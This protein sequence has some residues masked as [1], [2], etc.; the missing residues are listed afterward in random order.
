MGVAEKTYLTPAIMHAG[1]ISFA[2]TSWAEAAKRAARS[3]D[4]A[5]MAESVWYCIVLGIGG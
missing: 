4:L 2:A 5:N 3:V 1:G